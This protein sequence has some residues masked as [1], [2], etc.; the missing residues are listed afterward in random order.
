[1]VDKN[2]KGWLQICFDNKSEPL[3]ICQVTLAPI[4]EKE[5]IDRLIPSD[6]TEE[7]KNIY[8]KGE[9]PND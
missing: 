1:M 3:P 9:F 5:A 2:K 7:E 8:L 4:S 6:M